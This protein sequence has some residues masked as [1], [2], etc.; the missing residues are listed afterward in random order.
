MSRLKS[1]DHT[2]YITLARRRYN[3]AILN[4][5]VEAICSFFSVD[6]HVVTGGG[7]QSHG[8][9]EQ[10]QRWTSAFQSDSNVLYRRITRELRLTEQLG[11]AEELG[12]WVGKY[13]LDKKIV[14]VAGVYSAKWLRQA[15]DL[16]LVQAEIFTT[17]K[18][19]SCDNLLENSKLICRHNNGPQH[20]Y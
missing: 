8:I 7:I 9:E 4:R 10:H 11:F 17:L 19:R 14:L 1:L 13:T 18:F 15:N 5:N 20:N 3:D 16:W 6:Y 2:H 12:S